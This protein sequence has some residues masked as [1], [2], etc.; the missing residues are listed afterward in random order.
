MK[1]S[2]VHPNAP[3][4]R[5]R[6]VTFQDGEQLLPDHLAGFATLD[7]Y[8]DMTYEEWVARVVNRQNTNQVTRQ[9]IE[10]VAIGHF[11]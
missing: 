7:E 9:L 5:G 3:L 10:G 6:I 11:R 4:D 2:R 8:P 1:P